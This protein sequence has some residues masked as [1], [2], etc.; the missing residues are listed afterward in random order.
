MSGVSAVRNWTVQRFPEEAIVMLDDDITACVCMVSLRRRK[1][2]PDETL[3][4]LENSAYC[5][6]GARARLFGWHQRSDPRLLQRN[7]PFGINHWVGGAVGVIGKEPKWDE[8]LK[9]NIDASLTQLMVNRLV[10]NEA[11]F[12]FVQERDK[13][14]GGNSRWPID[15]CGAQIDSSYGSDS[16]SSTSVGAKPGGVAGADWLRVR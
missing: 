16:I 12:C 6:R 14:L 2:S 1:L 7:D 8:L 5:A 9:C 10:R 15:C 3:A 4:M 13:N 11:R